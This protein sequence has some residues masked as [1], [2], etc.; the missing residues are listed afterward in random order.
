MDVVMVVKIIARERKRK[1][2]KEVRLKVESAPP[3]PPY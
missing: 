2:R 3:V 1:P